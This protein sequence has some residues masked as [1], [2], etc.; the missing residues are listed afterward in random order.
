[1]EYGDIYFATWYTG[2]DTKKK[3]FQ[4]ALDANL[5]EIKEVLSSKNKAYG[6]SVFEPINVFF[7]GDA[8][9]AIDV[10]IDDKLSRIYRG[11]ELN[12]DTLL[13][14]IGYLILKRMNL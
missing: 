5:A 8:K 1:M 14:L 11:Q 13:D 7:K 4:E 9:A 3:T 10:R 6:N 12:D 2:E